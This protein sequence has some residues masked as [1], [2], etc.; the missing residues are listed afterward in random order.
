MASKVAKAGATAAKGAAG[1]VLK[2]IKAKDP[3]KIVKPK[4]KSIFNI[5]NGLRYYGVGSK[6][7]R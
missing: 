6:V 1:K 4:E 7:T 3:N 2:E 5:V